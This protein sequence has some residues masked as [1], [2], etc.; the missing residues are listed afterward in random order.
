VKPFS[1]LEQDRRAALVW[2]Q[3]SEIGNGLLPEEVDVVLGFE[4]ARNE[5]E[6]GLS[7]PGG[8]SQ[9]SSPPGHFTVSLGVG[10]SPF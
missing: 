2:V 6:F 3:A 9:T 4:A 5:V 8:A 10:S 1:I 7:H